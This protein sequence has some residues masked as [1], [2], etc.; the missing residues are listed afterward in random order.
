MIRYGARHFSNKAR[1]CSQ[2]FMRQHTFKQIP[3]IYRTMHVKTLTST[4]EANSPLHRLCT[5]VPR[6][7]SPKIILWR[8]SRRGKIEN[9]TI[10]EI[11]EP[12]LCTS[13]GTSPTLK[14][15]TQNLNLKFNAKIKTQRFNGNFKSVHP[16][17]N[18]KRTHML[19]ER[20]KLFVKL[21]TSP[22]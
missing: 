18:E 12:S 6:N 13:T 9:L 5:Q 1:R 14:T 16:T 2:L 3:T 10:T 7:F 21:L 20:F 22:R 19:I 4:L 15:G 17:L 11:L 8:F